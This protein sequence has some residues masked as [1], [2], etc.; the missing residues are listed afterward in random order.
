MNESEQH[1]P[2]CLRISITDRC[3][4]RCVYCMGSGGVEKFTHQDILSFTEIVRFV[5]V[6]KDHFGLGTV[7]I[8]GGEPLIRR[9]VV[10]LVRMLAEQSLSELTLTT[11]GQSLAAMAGELR[12]A[13]LNRVNISLDSLNADTY[14][15]LTRGGE[16]SRTLEGL[17]V[18][19]DSDLTPVKLNAVVLKGINSDEVVDMARFAIERGCEVRFLELMPIGPAGEHF[20][21][22]FFSSQEVLDELGKAFELEVSKTKFGSSS[23][24]Y[25]VKDSQG[26]RG[27][28][29]LISSG[30]SPFCKQCRR[31]RLTS[32]G[33]LIGC[34]ARPE[35]PNIRHLLQGTDKGDE[36]RLV[37]IISDVLGIKGERR[38]FSRTDSMVRIGG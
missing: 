9:G 15:R 34:L 23:R 35:G 18:A 5:Q 30:S 3:Q 1:G 10:E 7:R 36:S 31:L 17:T 32:T 33:K 2:V 20:S 4:H 16:L 38:L 14:R 12:R 8:T 13:G 24:G 26:R 22:W 27:S 19:L 29:G 6:L 11:N 37:E 21:D 25:L 28:I